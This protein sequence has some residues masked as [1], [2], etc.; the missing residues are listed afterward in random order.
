[1]KNNIDKLNILKHRET[2]KHK[3]KLSYHIYNYMDSSIGETVCLILQYVWVVCL[4]SAGCGGFTGYFLAARP[5][6]NLAF[7]HLK[8]VIQNA[9]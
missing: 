8:P 3:T 1:M 4:S 6:T 2:H 9:S 7:L 5:R